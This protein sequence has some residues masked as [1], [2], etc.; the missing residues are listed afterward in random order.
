MRIDNALRAIALIT[1]A[2]IV[3]T[4]TS[5]TALG[6][7]P[8][9]E[10]LKAFENL[11]QSQR[12]AILQQLGIVGGAGAASPLTAPGASTTPN[13]ITV[14]RPPTFLSDGREIG[15]DQRMTLPEGVAITGGEQ[16]LIELILIPAAPV[17]GLRTPDELRR[18]E[19]RRDGILK[20]NPFELTRHG[21]LQLPGFAPISLAGLTQKEAQQRL[22]LDPMLRDFSV[23]VSILRLQ[24]QGAKGL[25]PFGYEMFRS[26]STAFV[27][28][29]DI[30]VPPDYQLAPGDSLGVQ[31]YGQQNQNLTLPVGRDGTI[32][33]PGLGPVSVEGLGFGAA[34][35]MLQKRV[36]QQMIGTRAKVSI[37]DLRSLRVLVL[38]DAEKPGSYVVSGL[39]TVTN[40]LFV[41]GGVKQFG[42][43]RNIAVM[44]DGKL[45]RRLDLYDVLL[46]GDTSN[47]VRL[48]TGD[49][50]FIPPIGV[51]V[52]IYGGV[53]RPAIYELTR[54][55]TL[56]ELVAIAGGLG[57]DTDPSVVEV[58]RIKADGGDRE[59][60]SVDL[61]TPAGRAFA[62]RSGDLVR[63]SD[64]RP[65]FENGIALDGNVYRP[66]TYAW[67]SGVR[68]SDVIR[69]VEDL[70]PASDIHYVLVRRE[71][72]DSREV[73][74][75]SADLDAALRARGTDADIPLQ[76]RDRITV[77]DLISARDRV[78]TPLLDE[79]R[80]QASPAVPASVVYVDG[81]VNAPGAYPLEPGMRITDLIR[82]GGGFQDAAYA[83]G[84]ELTS[85]TVIGGEHRRADI[86]VVDLAAIGRGE[87]TADLKLRP[88]DVLSIKETP[89]W[90]RLEQIE[91]LGEVKFPG[92][93][94][95]R[96]GETLSSVL[97]RAGGLTVIAFAQGAVFT[98]EDLKL[99][100]KEQL[101]R[102]STRLQSDL[103]TMSLQAANSNSPGVAQSL[104]AGQGLLD[105]LRQSKPVGRLVVDLAAVAS[106]RGRQGGDVTLRNGDRLFV[107]RTTEEVSV[108]GEVQNATSHLY[109]QGLT[110]NAVI[111]LSGGT[112]RRADKARAYVVRAN[113]SVVVPGSR[114]LSSSDIDVQPGDTV[115]VPIDTER[116]PPLP[117]WTAIT[118]IIYN[119]A[120]ATAAVARL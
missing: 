103:A 118:S 25:K 104:A 71:S 39:S 11:P 4:L 16:L 47:D 86:Q 20:R 70:K 96:R 63:I 9:A 91:L 15:F 10:Q 31:L 23:A 108:L 119:L 17:D 29:T 87:K 68:L 109:R 46:K 33:F 64:A 18:L 66:G 113:G 22:A 90:G 27:P 93:Y 111:A 57:P 36:Q 51:M 56:T 45:I 102:L 32:S 44:R 26:S 76:S 83:N 101:E 61:S 58:E 35:S 92:K 106:D 28:G 12:E 116:M 41:S 95:I 6:Q 52:G 65:A 97:Q 7:A 107:P 48:Q 73:S 55:R 94:S 54:E 117:M 80:R 24:P 69:S 99:K 1:V 13:Q 14:Q 34:Q 2:A 112:T 21:V 98:R 74:V 82:A 37:V 110:R 50:V 60:V 120:V 43:L 3:L 75:L 59:V 115:V 8:T 81:R 78:I 40:V 67:R 114:W 62:L 30:P 19:S 105:Q 84:A 77:F 100:E 89:E 85:Y 5:E 79:L 53:Q 42:S 49:A 72:A 88:Y 38:G